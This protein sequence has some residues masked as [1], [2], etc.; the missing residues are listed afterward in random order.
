MK[1]LSIIGYPGA[2]KTTLMLEILHQL[3]GLQYRYQYG[4]LKYL[5]KVY[6]TS[7]EVIVLGEY[8]VG[9]WGGTDRLSMS[10]QPKAMEFFQNEHPEKVIWEG[11]RLGNASFFEFCQTL[12]NTEFKLVVVELSPEILAER[13]E[14]RE[15]E[16]G[17]K[18]DPV[19]LK[20]RETKIDNLKSDPRFKADARLVNSLADTKELAEELIEWLN[21]KGA[22]DL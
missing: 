9:A 18:Q 13:R 1:L 3:G 6:S 15:F 14:N 12:P 8:G 21:T 10:V 2:G 19:W 16:V 22:L 4:T 7:N 20:G 5:R 17:R 11:D